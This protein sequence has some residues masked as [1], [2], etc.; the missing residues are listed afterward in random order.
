[1]NIVLYEP[2]IHS[3]TGNIAR[4]CAI[5]G[6][7]LHL[8]KPL[9]FSLEDKYLKR[10]GLDYWEFLDLKIYENYQDFLE[11]N[12]TG[13]MYFLSTKGD[14]SY[15]KKVYGENDYLV[16]GPET[17]GLPIEVMEPNW[18]N[19]CKIPMGEKFRSLNLSNA[20]AIVLYEALRQGDFKGLK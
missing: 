2:E 5:T 10:A 19:V 15:T 20:V 17:R 1:M 4:T 12:Q 6:S 18:E 3:N 14:V 16:F 9:G 11:N 7:T 13:T 8:I